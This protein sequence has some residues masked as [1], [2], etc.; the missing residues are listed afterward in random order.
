M[1]SRL[2][3]ERQSPEEERV[4]ILVAK[5]NL[6]VGQRLAKPEELFDQKEVTRENEPPDAIREYDQLRNKLVK[7]PRNR[8]EHVTAANL[9]GD[10]ESLKIP[11]GYK[12][13]GM[14]VNLETTAAG[15]ATLPQSRVNLIWTTRGQDINTSEAKLLLESVL[16]LAADMKLNRDGELAS[17]AQVVTF[18]LTDEEIL[19]VSLAKENGTLS[20]ALRNLDDSSV[21]TKRFLKGGVLNQEIRKIDPALAEEPKKD[22]PKVAVA[23]KAFLP[24]EPNFT[25]EQYDV[26]QGAEHGVREVWR[27]YFNHF[28]DGT[29]EITG[30]EL[31]ETTK[32]DPIKGGA[33]AN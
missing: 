13:F 11:D 14:R 3:A 27:V 1:T 18:A 5:K 26:V 17:P 19:K 2:L 20:L 9:L 29:I 4:I 15:F 16:V 7:Q 28:D 10:N 25:K 30:R 12:A 33:K 24:D 31:I 21:A 23:P 8:G 6:S 32:I 22:T